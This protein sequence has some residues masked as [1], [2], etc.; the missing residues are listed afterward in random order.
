M[1]QAWMRAANEDERLYLALE[2]GT[3]RGYLNQLAGGH[4]DA[5]PTLAAAIERVTLEM[6]EETQGRLPVVYRTDLNSSCAGCAFAAQCLGEHVV[7]RR[8]FPVVEASQ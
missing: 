2:A 3:S 8:E 7:M 4:R 5:S 6:R 1:M